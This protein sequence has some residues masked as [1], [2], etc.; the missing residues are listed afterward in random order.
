MPRLVDVEYKDMRKPQKA[1]EMKRSRRF[2]KIKWK[3][4]PEIYEKKIAE[5]R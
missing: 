2:V 4:E 3:K 5:E 1:R